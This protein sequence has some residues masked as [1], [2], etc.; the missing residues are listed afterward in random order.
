MN[1]VNPS[2]LFGLA[3]LAIPVIIHLF[4]FR[5]YKRVYFADIRFLKEIS[6]ETASKTKLKHLL[7]LLMRL[8][9]IAA[10]VLAFAQPFIPSD[11]SKRFLPASK[12]SLYIDNSF[13]MTQTT[14]SGTLL[15]EAVLKAEEI[16]LAFPITTQFQLITNDFEGRHQRY[17][18]REE[19]F[20]YLSEV[21]V[22]PASRKTNEVLNRIND[23]SATAD[24]RNEVFFISDFKKNKGSFADLK[25]D[26]LLTLNLIPLKPMQQ[27]NIS[28][29]SVWFGQP[30]QLP[31]E[32]TR[33]NV[34][35][36]NR[37]SE[38]VE[39]L[40]VRLFINDKQKSVAT[41]EIEP[42]SKT[43]VSLG[44]TNA[45]NGFQLGK[46]EIS[47]HP[48]DFD[49]Q[50]YFSYNLTRRI[51]VISIN[52][53]SENEFLNL[54]L[55]NDS[56][57]AFTNV[58]PQ[59]IDYSKL[60]EYPFIILNEWNTIPEGLSTEIIR[61]LKSGASLLIIPPSE[62]LDV[63]S[64]NRFLSLLNLPNLQQLD[65]TRTRVDE[66][67]YSHPLYKDVFELEKMKGDNI[68]YPT[69][70]KHYSTQTKGNIGGEKI[71]GLQNNRPLLYLNYAQG[72]IAYFLSTNLSDQ[73]GNFH[74]HAIFVPTLY[75]MALLSSFNRGLYYTIGKDN[76]I[77]IQNLK[78]IKEIVIRIKGKGTQKEFI[79]GV[80]NLGFETLLQ[81]NNL[82]LEED[83]YLVLNNE[84]D[85][86]DIISMNYSR[87][88]SDMQSFSEEEIKEAL[89]AN[90]YN[91]FIR[92]WKQQSKSLTQ[93]ISE[94]Q[95]GIRLWKWMLVFALMFFV[96]ETLILR[97]MK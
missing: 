33:I 25:G 19:L 52:Q 50:L 49:N 92:F 5:R 20:Q 78:N 57:I 12:V 70:L 51:N 44:F 39:D 60:G 75:R 85:T 27:N 63:A 1:F 35:L 41:A 77:S 3:A 6:E 29:D 71:I 23:L 40:P 24:G 2:L 79:P 22:S 76:V 80:R 17:V 96:A 90:P 26:S 74:R 28:I 46:V 13:S 69:I 34:S 15:N 14:E 9:A 8:L 47:D 54:L 48:V 38:K 73:S 82:L 67:N 58:N 89:Q 4:Q 97:F 87:L 84:N 59:S 94:E 81:F 56:S 36:H 21:K 31:N 66:I 64:Y 55:G 16:A 65:T 61:N 93:L 86:L 42:F 45:E 68:N 95:S 11:T 7:V 30:V 53:R 10:L 91:E 83:N 62:Q 37:G 18:N 32:P 72:G 88:N 43:T